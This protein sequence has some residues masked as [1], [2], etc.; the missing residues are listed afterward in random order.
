MIKKNIK[1]CLFK[2][3]IPL[4]TPNVTINHKIKLSVFK[5]IF[6]FNLNNHKLTKRN[7]ENNNISLFTFIDNDINLSKL[8]FDISKLKTSKNDVISHEYLKFLSK[9]IT[10]E[11]DKEK[12]NYV[13][14]NYKLHINN[15]KSVEKYIKHVCLEKYNNDIKCLKKNSNN[16]SN[17]NSKYNLLCSD[18]LQQ[19]IVLSPERCRDIKQYHIQTI[20][21][22]S[23]DI[24]FFFCTIKYNSEIRIYKINLIII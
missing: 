7:I 23:N 11:K 4:I 21:L 8:I 24:V 6:C 16:N 13:C 12:E 20:P 14:D 9:N 22:I 10:K 1:I 19:I 2:N 5:N 18:L 17:D 3:E 15:Y